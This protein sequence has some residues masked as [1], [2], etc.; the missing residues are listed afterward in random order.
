MP[1]STLLKISVSAFKAFRWHKRELSCVWCQIMWLKRNYRSPKRPSIRTLFKIQGKYHPN[2]EC[3]IPSLLLFGTINIWYNFQQCKDLS[4]LI[5][6][7]PLKPRVCRGSGGVHAR[8]PRAG[9]RWF[10]CNLITGCGILIKFSQRSPWYF[11]NHCWIPAAWILEGAQH[12]RL[13]VPLAA[14][15]CEISH[16]SHTRCL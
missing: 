7:L 3:A 9:S 15:H 10:H 11:N 8:P 6:S 4:E 12:H 14:L 16:V 2:R 13:C 5:E 1:L